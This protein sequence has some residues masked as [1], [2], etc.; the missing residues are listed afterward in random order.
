MRLTS[1]HDLNEIM[2]LV[3]HSLESAAEKS[4]R[5]VTLQT[6]GRGNVKRKLQYVPSIPYVR[7]EKTKMTAAD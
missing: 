1:M 2:K 5:Y 7:E 3:V 6:N 4:A